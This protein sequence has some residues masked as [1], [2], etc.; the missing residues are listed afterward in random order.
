[1]S[2]KSLEKQEK[3]RVQLIIDVDK[4]TFAQAVTK[5]FKKNIGKINVPGFRK[6][7]APRA[8]VE[9]Y[10]GE[11][12]FYDDAINDVYPAALEE[13]IKE[14]ELNVIDDRPEL[15]VISVGKDGLEFKAIV[16]VRPEVKIGEYKGLKATKV[17]KPVTDEQVDAQL[18]RMQEQNARIID[19]ED[20]ASENGDTVVMDFEG[21]ID[22]QAFEGGKGEGYELVLGSN[23]F[24]PGF[25]DQMVGHNIDDK[26][27]VNVKFPEDYHASDLAGK[28]AVFKVTVHN[29][30]K[31]ELPELDDEFAKD[32]SEYDT[33]DELKESI[34]KEIAERQEKAA[35]DNVENQLID[36]ILKDVEA[37]IPDVMIERRVDDAIHDFAHRL[38]HQGLDINTYLQYTNL[39]P[40]TFRNS[41][42]PNAEKQVKVRLALEEIV[43]AENIEISD[44]ELEKE[45]QNLAEQYKTDLEKVKA[46]IPAEDLKLDLAVGKA[47]EIIKANADVTVTDKEPE[48]VKVDDDT[49][50]S[51]Y[52]YEPIDESEDNKEEENQA[53]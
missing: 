24:I 17:I 40:E 39:D 47:V 18:S 29:I 44:E 31:K 2:L 23:T 50:A 49:Q 34:K 4:D 46:V 5:S 38:Q 42:K 37:D 45:F 27:D 26:F 19:V 41:F 9:K 30:K 16:A 11:D 36:E 33:L 8:F 13:A 22:G 25:E 35:E 53:E 51:G 52:K 12:I 6:G 28:D 3:S 10:Y 1:M 43:K 14:S 32:V 7:K 21:F 15:E 20:R 48:P